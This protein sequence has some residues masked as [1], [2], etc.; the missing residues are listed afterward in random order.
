[1]IGLL[2]ESR[3]NFAAARTIAKPRSEEVDR[4]VKMFSLHR[5]PETARASGEM[6]VQGSAL[7]KVDMLVS[8]A[9]RRQRYPRNA[10][11]V[12][13]LVQVLLGVVFKVIDKSNQYIFAAQI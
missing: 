10:N 8:H 12:G 11:E 6:R 3:E 1:M 2:V 13:N 7:A 9:S 4:P 5:I